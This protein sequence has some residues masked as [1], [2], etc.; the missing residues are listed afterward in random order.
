MPPSPLG[1]YLLGFHTKKFSLWRKVQKIIYNH[2]W[3][4]VLLQV[5]IKGLVVGVTPHYNKVKQ[6]PFYEDGD[7]DGKRKCE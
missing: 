6:K 1:W 4:H 2:L 3:P 5:P 7:N